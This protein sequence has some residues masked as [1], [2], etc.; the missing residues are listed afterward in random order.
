MTPKDHN[1]LVGIFLIIHGGFQGLLMLFVS[2]VYGGIGMAILFG[3]K[4]DEKFVG[5]IFFAVIA[6][7]AVISTLMF[8]PQIIGGWKMFKEKPNAKLWG[9][10]GS[11]IACVSFPLG[12]AAGVYGLWFLFGEKGKMYELGQ[13][14][15]NPSEYRAQPQDFY[16]QREPHSW[17]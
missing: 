3:G 5:L 11:S 2:L 4:N 12:T 7:M 9:T 14:Q 17:R 10:I 6:F 15:L 8:A 13:T 1:R 16:Q